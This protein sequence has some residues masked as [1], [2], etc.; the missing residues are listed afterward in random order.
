MV[1]DTRSARRSKEEA[2]DSSTKKKVNVRKDPSTRSTDVSD[3]RSA[4]EASS[5][6]P[7]T[8]N[9]KSRASS[10]QTTTSPQI[11]RKS[12]RLDKGLPALTPPMKRKSERLEK[13]NTPSPVRRSDRGK[14]NLASNASGSKQPAKE[15][16]S[17]GSKRRKEKTLIELTTES[18]KAEVDLE[19]VGNKKRKMM[20]A[21]SFRSIFKK[22]RIKDIVLDGDGDLEGRDK[23]SDV[24]SG[25]SKGVDSNKPIGND[26]DISDECNRGV[27]GNLRDESIDKTDNE[28]TRKSV[29]SSKGCHTD[30]ENDV[31]VDSGLG[32]NVVG[33][34]CSKDSQNSLSVRETFD[35]T[36][37]SS[38]ICL[39]TDN[40]DAQKSVCSSKGCHTDIENDVIVDSVLG[41]NVVVDPCS[42]DSQTS[43]SVREMFDNTERSSKNCLPIDN[44]DAQKSVCSLK[45]CHTDIKNDVIV[46]SGL[47]DNVV[48]DPCS[49]DSLTS[50][51]VRETFD[52]TERS[53]KNC[54]STDTID[55]QKSICSLKGCHTDIEHDV[56]VDSRLGDN[57]VVDPCSKDSHTSLSVRETFNNTERSSKNCLSTDNIDAPESESSTSLARSQDGSAS[58]VAETTPSPSPSS[59]CESCDLLGTCV[60][61][62]KIK[63]VGYDSPEQELCS[64]NSAVCKELDSISSCKC[65]DRSDQG[66]AV[67]SESAEKCDSRHLLKERHADSQMNGHENVCALCYKGGELLCCEGKGCRR[68]YHLSCLD[69]PLNDSVPGV[70]HCSQCVKKK[71]LFGVHSVSEGVE[72]I[73]DVRE[74]GVSNAEVGVRQR[75][76]LVT[77]HGLAHIHNHWVPETQLLLEYSS[78]VSNFVEKDQAVKWSPEWMV[79]HRLLLKRYIQDKIYIASSDVIS[80]C[81]YEWLVKWRG[82]SYDHATWELEDSYFL[83]SPLGQKLVKDYEIRCQKAKQEVNKHH[84]GSIVKLSELP[85]SQS[86]VNDNDVLKNVNKLREFLLKGQ[87]AVAF[88]D[89]E[90][91]VAIILFIRSMSEIGW[92]FLVVT[93]S[94]S[95]SQWEAEFARLVPSVD[96]VVYSGNRNTRKGI[97]ASEFNEGGSRVMFQVLL[98]SA[99]AVLEDLDRLRSIKWEAIVIDGYKQS[100]IS[101]DLEQIRVLSTELRILILS[102]QIKESTSEYL[103]ILSLLE[104]DG[105]FDKLAGL[106]SD[107]N[108]NICKLKDRLSR[109]IANGSTSQVSR[110]IEYWLPVQMSNFQLEEYCDT[111]LSNSIYLRSCSKNDHVGALQDILL[112]VRKCCD[113]PYLLDSSVQGSLIAEQRPA[114]EIL[115]YGVKASGKLELLD[116]IL[117][118]IKMRGLRVLVLYQ[119]IIGSGGA[120][121]GDILDD[122]LRQ[123]FGQYT[124]ERIDAGVLR[125]KKQA[126]LNRFNKKETE[127]FVFLLETRACASIIKLS[128]VDVIII[129]DSDWNPANDLR[130]LQKISIDSKVEHIKVF[131]L[132]SSFT[133]EERALILAKQNLNLDN[134]LQNFSRTT[135]NTLL[136]W[137]AMYLFSKLDEYHADNKSN[138]ALNVSSGQLLL[139]E[140][141][142]EFKAILSGSENTDS[143]SIISKVKLG[144]GSYNTN[145]STLGETKLELKDEEEPHIFWRN[146]LDGKN[147]QWK[148]L[149]G[150]C[151]RNRK[152]VNYLDGSPSKLE[153]EKHDVSKKRKKML[154]KNP[155]P[156][157]VEVELG[158]HQ[159]TQVAVPEGGHSTTIKPCNQSQDLRSDSTPNNKPNSISVQRSFGDEASVAVSEEKNVSSDEKKSLHNFLQGE[160]MRLCQILKVSEEVTNVAR[161]FLDYVMKNHHFNS[162]S[163]SIV[164][165]FQISLYWNAASI[166]KQKVDKKNSLMLAEQLLNY[167]CTEEQ[168]STVYLK[169]RSLKRNYLQCSENNINSGSD[170]LI[171]EEDISKEPNVNEWSSQSSSHN[172]RNLNNEIREKSANEEHAEGQVLLQQKVTSNDNKTGS[173][174]LIN[175]LKKIQKKCDKRTKKLE[176]KHQQEIQEFHRVWEEKR[177]K[178]ETDHKLESAFIRSIHGQGSVRVD[179]LKLLDSNFAKKMEEHNLLKDVQFRDLEAEQLAAINEERQ[180]AALWLDKAKVCSGEVG[181]VNRPQSLGSQSGDDAAPS[182]TSSSPPAEAIDPKTSVENSGTACAQ[183][184][185]KVV[186]LENSSSRM[187][188]HLIS[189]NSA[190]KGETVSADLPAPVE[191]VSD[192]IQ[193][194]ELS[195]ECPIEVSKTVRNKF[196]GHVHPVELSD[197]SKESSDQGSGNALPNALVSQKDGTDETASGELLQSLGQTL[198]HSEQTVAMPDCSDLFAGQ[199][200]QDKLDQSLAA[201]EIR[202][203]DAPAVENQS[204]S[205]VARSALVDTVAPS[206]SIPEAT[207]IDEVVTPIPTNLE[208]PVTDEV[209]NPVAS[210]VESP[211]DISLSL[212]QSPTIEDHDQGRSSSQ[213]VEPRVTGVA[214]ESISR[215]AENVEIR[216]SG[217]LDIIVPMTGVAHTQSVELSDVCQNDI[218]IPQVRMGT[219]GQPNQAGLQLETGAGHGPNYFLAPPAHRHIFRNSAPSFVADPLQHELERIRK[220]TEQLQKNHENMMSQINSDCEKEIEEIITQIRKK[221]DVKLQETKAEFRLKK[222]ELETNQNIVH[223]NKVLAEAFRLKC[224]S[225]G[226]DPRASGLPVMEQ[227]VSSLFMPRLPHL[228]MAPPARPSPGPSQQQITAPAGQTLQQ[229]VSRPPSVRPPSPGSNQQQ[230][231]APAVQTVQQQ[232]SRPPSVR[233]FAG[234]SQQQIAA[235]AVQTVQQQVLRQPSMRPSIAPGQSVA[236]AATPPLVQAIQDLLSS[237]SSSSRPP[238]LI[239][240]I[241][242]TRNPLR[243]GCEIRSRAPHLQP[244]RPAASIPYS[245]S[246]LQQM[247]PSQP[248]LQTTPRPPGPQTQAPP[249]RPPLANP[250]VPTVAAAATDRC[251]NNGGSN[252]PEICS[253]FGTLELSDL[254]IISNVQDNQTSRVV[255]LSDDE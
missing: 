218:A 179:K 86:L 14:K 73:W 186:S 223:M 198:V 5:S 52:N 246:P 90:Q 44:I 146:L 201:A 51:S 233:P 143:D 124:Y 6:R 64:C 34:P 105:D 161:R 172:A 8:P 197:A 128:S 46:D 141:V 111:L 24:C 47:G 183:N 40:I 166:T 27:V 254:E 10:R 173:C 211:V 144:V 132:Y 219:A 205:E 3:P 28:A 116:S 19:A 184:G 106:K 253:T 225:K 204:T 26:E 122:F 156:A 18:K 240:S 190:D 239:S 213:T 167:Q 174:E 58:S 108:E 159:V 217:R 59:K 75:Q 163:P 170:C 203:L 117:T 103:K 78:L 200:Q 226:G 145:V 187:V 194:V 199:V 67:T 164:Q 193:P 12:K 249:P 131:R 148:H 178:L 155:D 151:R 118:E 147:P 189:N 169:M 92:P 255:C 206:P 238:L 100:E 110:L 55:A 196:V 35:N 222:N 160:M 171:A 32:N 175:K 242:P 77:Y 176:R 54:L 227:G 48:V 168:A 245:S 237:S 61:C 195:E 20:D 236:A 181:T 80:V 57:V 83:S 53:S 129:F 39:S 87:N 232:V 162:D 29:C 94:S 120:S 133:V 25:N 23:V 104:S 208:A 91:A 112:T 220:E 85:A 11:M 243:L 37:R 41:D 21:R 43:L 69:P 192:E 251:H 66:A 63:R 95:V 45:G 230:I 88:N 180:K 96:V 158:V 22:Q 235:P 123:R 136:R 119:L 49:K 42:K 177:V 1:S 248:G 70:W 182:I 185:G 130:A 140:V 221:Y 82:L 209:V 93:G 138:M 212:N 153:A 31:I 84:K 241:T 99:E 224:R 214:Q 149:K 135:S 215:S 252:L 72:S 191:K 125:S 9:P 50:L 13:H 228:S 229:Q 154:N 30:I 7:T 152:R 36:E 121:T 247:Q 74:V 102:G 65:K 4:R 127:Q 234:P 216:S 188:E 150:P 109:F 165:A 207:V 202:D 250:P 16:S 115:D 157:I 60:L 2:D 81:N 79:P 17:S 244:F 33:Q 126:A 114:A 210:N 137:G 56:I 107:T 98:S 139:N 113:H 97:R 89:Q 62:S 134:N 101:I 68:C 76:Y 15:L 231:V 142:K 38:K 71:I